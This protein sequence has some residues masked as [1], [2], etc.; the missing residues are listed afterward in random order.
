MSKQTAVDN[1][2]D[3]GA[4]EGGQNSAVYAEPVATNHPVE[5][6]NNENVNK[7]DGT[8]QF[9][10]TQSSESPDI[11]ENDDADLDKELLPWLITEEQCLLLRGR[12]VDFKYPWSMR[13]KDLI[14]KLRGIDLREKDGW[15]QNERLDSVWVGYDNEKRSH[16]INVT[17]ADKGDELW[18]VKEVKLPETNDEG[19]VDHKNEQKWTEACTKIRCIVTEEKHYVIEG[20]FPEKEGKEFRFS[21]P[22]EEGL[23]NTLNRCGRYLGGGGEEESKSCWFVPEE[24]QTITEDPDQAHLTAHIRKCIDEGTLDIS[25]SSR[26]PGEWIEI[27]LSEA[28]EVRF[29]SRQIEKC[30]SNPKKQVD[31]PLGSMPERSGGGG[32]VQRSQGLPVEIGSPSLT[33]DVLSVSLFSAE[34]LCVARSYMLLLIDRQFVTMDEA[35]TLWRAIKTWAKENDKLWCGIGNFN[36]DFLRQRGKELGLRLPQLLTS[37]IRNIATEMKDGAFILVPFG[38]NHCVAVDVDNSLCWDPAAVKRCQAIKM[39]EEGDWMQQISPEWKGAVAE[40]YK[41]VTTKQCDLCHAEVDP[42]MM[43]LHRDSKRCKKMQRRLNSSASSCPVAV[44]RIKKSITSANI[45]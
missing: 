23:I 32:V 43:K 31:I 34:H 12:A 35:S 11:S 29:I 37:P 13:E 4:D 9:P 40:C 14:P 28:N 17:V 36:D 18:D 2:Q 25:E 42:S 16:V 45:E 22:L 7:V 3:E 27:D 33:D 26:R 10:H 21:E 39:N 6:T 44:K 41:F 24:N 8:H 1:L 30:C 20:H 15:V 19:T 5:D 38:T